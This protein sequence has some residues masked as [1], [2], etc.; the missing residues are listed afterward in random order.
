MPRTQFDYQGAHTLDTTIG[1]LTPHTL[2]GG[3]TPTFNLVAERR[4]HVTPAR[5]ALSRAFC[6]FTCRPLPMLPC[7]QLRVQHTHKHT[8]SNG[9]TR[10]ALAA[11]L[12]VVERND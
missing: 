10:S 3:C 7:A 4:L 5:T 12:Y 1:S 9:Y 8:A 11:R 6:C 2:Q